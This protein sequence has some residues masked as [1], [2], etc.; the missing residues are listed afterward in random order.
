MR[1]VALAERLEARV[2][3]VVLVPEVTRAQNAA[4]LILDLQG[5]EGEEIHGPGCVIQNVIAILFSGQGEA[6][7]IV[8][9]DLRLEAGKPGAQRFPESLHVPRRYRSQG[10]H[11]PCF[12]GQ[13]LP[14]SMRVRAA[15]A[16]GEADRRIGREDPPPRSWIDSAFPRMV[17][18]TVPSQ[19]CRS[20]VT[21]AARPGVRG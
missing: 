10:I 5:R 13:P 18:E 16:E 12:L 19:S 20:P 15:T 21:R 17:K 1:R 7:S 3:T 8:S 11:R 2:H 9:L 4:A 14:I 6:E